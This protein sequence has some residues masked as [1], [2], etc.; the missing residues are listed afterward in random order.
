MK[1]NQPMRILLLIIA[2]LAVANFS[3]HEYIDRTAKR[4][5]IISAYR[6]NAI[7]AC[8]RQAGNQIDPEVWNKPSGVKLK[9]GKSD[10]DVYLWQTK[11]KLWKARYQNPYL[12]VTLGTKGAVIY[13]DYDISNDTASVHATGART[14]SY[15]DA[16]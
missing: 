8:Q 1:W 5:I 13:C 7:A 2:V 14:I 9:I 3:V 6:G 4:D 15:H 16:G 12:Y 11:H 10:L